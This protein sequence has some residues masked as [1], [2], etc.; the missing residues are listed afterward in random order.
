MTRPYLIRQLKQYTDRL[1]DVQL[2]V[3]GSEARGDA[4]DK[5]D[6]D[7]LILLDKDSITLS[8][9][10]SINDIFIDFEIAQGIAVNPFIDTTAHWM[11]Q[12]SLFH[13]NVNQDRVAL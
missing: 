5:S 11:Q 4:H 9:R 8:D 2:W 12:H 10:M 1:Q 6:I 3:Y 13:E 7:L